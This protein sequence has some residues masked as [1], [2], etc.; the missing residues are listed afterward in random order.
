MIDSTLINTISLFEYYK[1]LGER[2]IVQV[3]DQ[4]LWWVPDAKSNSIS[5]IVKHLHGNMLSRWTDFLTTD[6]EK[7]WRQRDQEFEET[8]QSRD[9]MMK[10]WDEGWACLFNALGSLHVED[11]SKIVYIRN[12]GQSAEEAIMRQLAHYAYH[13]GQIV[14]LARLANEGDWKSLS[15]PKGESGTYNQD[16]FDKEKSIEHF[17]KEILGK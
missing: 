6:G 8:I 7:E 16:K 3:Q 17:T 4:A 12:M 2:A 13:V 1:S 10:L 15:I 9:E 11:L 14:Y 5:L